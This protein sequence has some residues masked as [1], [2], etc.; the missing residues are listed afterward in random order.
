LRHVA[1]VIPTVDRIGGAERQVLLMASGLCRRGWRV[2]VVALSGCGGDAADEL[3]DAGA[4]F[5]ALGMR[6][7]WADPRGWIRLNRWLKRE[8]PDVVH[9][10]L[11]HAAWLARWSRL[12]APVRVAVDTLH[13]SST[14]ALGRRLGYRAS[15]WLTDQLTAVSNAVADAHRS[16][17]ITRPEK[18]V[19]LANG[20][21]VRVWHADAAVRS[22]VRRK[23]SVGD[24]FLWLAAGRLEPVKDY[25][26]LLS[27]MAQVSEP[28]RLMIAGSGPLLGQ[29][30]QQ[31]EQLGLGSRVI[32][33]GFEA[34]LQPW[35]QAADGF[36][37]SSLWEGLPMGLLE[38]A[39]CGLP[40]IATDAQGTREVIL[41]GAT[42]W[43]TPVGD[44]NALA[45]SMRRLMDTPLK[46]RRAMGNCARERAMKQNGLEAIL[47]KWE[48]LYGT[49][50][51]QNQTP[52]RWRVPASQ[53]SATPV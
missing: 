53:R 20:V 28:S 47:D 15:D 1:L 34:D 9:S 51:Q 39:A 2:T 45:E 33:L 7:G 4:G 38:A 37:L 31:A 21:D 23:L 50:L 44:A 11:P 18:L 16:A 27:A 14:G 19:V 17:G 43:L 25:P 5:V 30:S 52:A 6:K 32:F 22:A 42:G 8:K 41:N 40:A 3:S 36:V 24:E 49:L 10:H 26:T 13:S 12:L 29:L 46:D 35:M 48:E